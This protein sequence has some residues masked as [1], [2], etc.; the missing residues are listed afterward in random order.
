MESPPLLFFRLFCANLT[1]SA[2]FSVWRQT[3][4]LSWIRKSRP[5]RGWITSRKKTLWILILAQ[6]LFVLFIPVW[7]RRSLALDRASG[8]FSAFR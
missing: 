1:E 3:F 8:R 6:A 4:S 2:F 5:R 7:E